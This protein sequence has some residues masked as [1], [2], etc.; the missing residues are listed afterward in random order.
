MAAGRPLG[1]NQ[2]FPAAGPRNTLICRGGI[3]GGFLGFGHDLTVAVSRR[4]DRLCSATGE[5]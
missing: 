5:N 2:G 3:I 1:T 4:A